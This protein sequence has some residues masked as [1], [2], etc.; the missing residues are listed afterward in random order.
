MASTRSERRAERRPVVI[1][2]VAV[3]LLGA[4]IASDF[5]IGSFWS[6]HAMLTSL[7]ASLL[8]VVISVAVINEIIER[9]ERRRWNLL[10]QGVLFALTQSARLTWTTMVEV[11]RLTEV[12]SGAVESLLEGAKVAFD[13]PRVSGAARELLADPARRQRLQ[14]V[15]ERLSDHYSEVIAKW[16]N[17][18]VGAAPYASLLERHVELQARLEWLASVLAHREPVP[19]GGRGRRLTM[20]SIAT[21]RADEFGD[22]WIHDMVV[23]ITT[24]AT[25]LDHD[26]RTLAFSLFSEQW[27]IDRTQA[28]LET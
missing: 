27:W 4:A 1:G 26:S 9:R 21:E 24:M 5:I 19:E 10:A 20:A 15:V 13:R 7:A 6:K 11:L 25:R 23:V 12:Q 18:L 2:A 3:A 16:A 14:I 8:V 22:D 17:V 28:L